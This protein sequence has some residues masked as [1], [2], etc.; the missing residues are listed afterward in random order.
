MP[1]RGRDKDQASMRKQCCTSFSLTLSLSLY[2][3][4]ALGTESPGLLPFGI[5]IVEVL[6]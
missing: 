6:G 5:Q 1:R 2:N 3:P 4:F